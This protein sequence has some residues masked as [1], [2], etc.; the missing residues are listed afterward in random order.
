MIYKNLH[1]LQSMVQLIYPSLTLWRP[2]AF[3][4]FREKN[5]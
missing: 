4:D 3:G 1:W 5:T 2:A